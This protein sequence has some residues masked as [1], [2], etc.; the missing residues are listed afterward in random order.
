MTER[1]S[2]REFYR[3]IKE[4]ELKAEPMTLPVVGGDRNRVAVLYLDADSLGFLWECLIKA[5]PDDGFTGI[6]EAMYFRYQ[7]ILEARDD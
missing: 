5:A 3:G 7:D 6:V 2:S 4:R 1:R